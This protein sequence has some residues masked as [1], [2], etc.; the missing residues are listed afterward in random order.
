MEQKT[1]YLPDGSRKTYFCGDN[2]TWLEIVNTVILPKWTKYCSSNWISPNPDAMYSSERRVKGFLDRLAWLLLGDIDARG[3]MYKEMMR[4]VREIPVSEC[5][6]DVEN[7]LMSSAKP[8]V[9]GE[10]SKMK[11]TMP[12]KVA[13]P[14]RKKKK[15]PEDWTTFER[16]QKLRE[17]YPTALITFCV[18]NTE[19]E[20]TYG[21]KRYH[22]KDSVEQYHP[23]NTSLGLLYDMDQIAVV[24]AERLHWYDQKLVPIADDDIEIL[25]D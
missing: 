19:N 20:F 15:P 18:V 25:E 24:D 13:S 16:A 11:D 1:V 4:E 12:E 17:T 7:F 6:P 21:G 22:I 3:S 23:K 2:Q 8:P 9:T 10:D 14:K 5:S